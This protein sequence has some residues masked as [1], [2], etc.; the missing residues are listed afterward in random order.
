MTKICCLTAVSTSRKT[1]CNFKATGGQRC[2]KLLWL[3]SP[4]SA[5]QLYRC[6]SD[7]G[8][9]M[10]CCFHLSFLS[11]YCPAERARTEELIKQAMGL[12]QDWNLIWKDLLSISFLFNVFL[13]ISLLNQNCN[14]LPPA[15]G[16]MSSQ[17]NLSAG[18]LP[19]HA[20]GFSQHILN[21]LFFIKR[22]HFLLLGHGDTSIIIFVPDTHTY[23]YVCI[24]TSPSPPPLLVSTF[25]WVCCDSLTT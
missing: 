21:P 22:R 13:L 10:T 6:V 24:H 5:P 25:N 9:D 15:P 23:I 18:F 8:R 1:S 12:T 7:L 4:T 17:R 16:R 20:P 11:C 3:N 14:S 2:L 19:G